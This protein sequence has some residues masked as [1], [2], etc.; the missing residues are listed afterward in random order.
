M[1]ARLAMRAM[2]KAT[3]VRKKLT[4][5]TCTAD[6]CD[7]RPHGWYGDDS[8]LP[9]ANLQCNGFDFLR[10]VAAHIDL[11][12]LNYAGL[13]H[14]CVPHLAQ[15]SERWGRVDVA[16]R[17]PFC[18]NGPSPSIETA[19][20]TGVAHGGVP[21]L[22]QKFERRGALTSRPG[23][24]IARTG[25]PPRVRQLT[26]VPTFPQSL[27]QLVPQRQLIFG[28]RRMSIWKADFMRYVS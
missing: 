28:L 1:R 17:F 13:A 14:G 15:N 24:R 20:F 9:K 26:S 4:S 12:A 23:S 7:E 19:Y 2:K 8:S 21:R 5:P 3:A 10:G 22:A 27:C 25:R 16:A 6:G 18:Q 11:G